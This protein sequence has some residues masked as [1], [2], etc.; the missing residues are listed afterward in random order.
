RIDFLYHLRDRGAL[1]CA[2]RLPPKVLQPLGD[3]LEHRLLHRLAEILL[4]RSCIHESVFQDERGDAA[5]PEPF[6]HLRA[7]ALPFEEMEPSAGADDYRCAA[8]LR[9]V[10]QESCQ[11]GANDIANDLFA[12]RVVRMLDF[13]LRPIL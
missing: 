8:G 9:T 1:S 6:R 3:G 2:W 13:L 11:C 4:R 7:L 10:G 5:G 12:V